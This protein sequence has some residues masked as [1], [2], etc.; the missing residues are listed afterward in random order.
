[1]RRRNANFQVGFC[2]TAL[3]RRES[4]GETGESDRV[5]GV[6]AP[7]TDVK[8]EAK[9]PLFRLAR[10]SVWELWQLAPEALDQLP[11]SIPGRDKSLRRVRPLLQHHGAGKP[12]PKKSS[13]QLPEP[14]VVARGGS[15]EQSKMAVLVSP[16]LVSVPVDNGN[17][18]TE[19]IHE[20]HV[21]VARPAL[22]EASAQPGEG[23]ESMS[24]AGTARLPRSASSKQAGIT[25]TF[26][27]VVSRSSRPVCP[28]LNRRLCRPL[29]SRMKERSPVSP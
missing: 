10:L 12:P 27:L 3:A 24:P 13:D 4:R 28:C 17:V 18:V 7:L 21:V 15:R 11:Q 19:Q 9:G 22:S 1:M 2:Q 16:I 25:I 20:P 26:C 23:R 6:P 29:S 14:P 5:A 8:N